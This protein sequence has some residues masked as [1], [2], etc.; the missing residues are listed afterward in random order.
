MAAIWI[1]YAWD[2]NRDGDID[3]VAQELRAAGLRVKLDRWN[4]RAGSRLWPQIEQFI[5]EPAES[6]AWLL[7]ATN[8]SLSSEPC[9]EE[10]AYA[11]QRAL[12]TRGSEYPVI[13]LFLGGVDEGLIP[14]GV[15]TRLYVSITDVDWKE[16]ILAAAE[17]R[18]PEIEARTIAPY[19]LKVHGPAPDGRY[20][21][22]ARPRA[23]VWA[24]F[25]AAIPMDEKE[26]VQPR[27]M[28]G[29]RDVP[30][31]SGMLI[32]A[33]QSQSPDGASWVMVAGN[34]ANPTTSY[35]VWCRKLPSK[36]TFGVNG[37][38][39]QYAVTFG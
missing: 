34:Q 36:L 24:P 32:G 7:V 4:V 17:G 31:G 21:I 27:I 29:P 25:L 38:P 33:G 30:T 8:A 14:A 28:I 9:K 11:L 20:A 26:A 13:A 1:T 23:G 39:P 16:R 12:E 10:Y 3:F 19:V 5:M 15:R 2:D 18:S 37:G 22:E 6:D 35:Y